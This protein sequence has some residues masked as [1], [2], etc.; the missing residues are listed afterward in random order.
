[1]NANIQH[2]AIFI[3]IGLLFSVTGIGQ[4]A[5]SFNQLLDSIADMTP[6]EKNKTITNY[7]MEKGRL[8][9]I[10]GDTVVFLSRGLGDKAPRI[11]SGFTGFLNPRY[12]KDPE[13]GTMTNIED[14]HWFFLEKTLNP[15]A[16]IYYQIHFGD[17]RNNDPLNPNLGFRFTLINSMVQMPDFSID[18]ELV[19]D[20]FA[21]KG[22][23]K[24]I[25]I[26]SK[27]L[28][29]IRTPKVYLPAGYQDS[30]NQYPTLYFHDGTAYV[31]MGKVPQILDYLIAHQKIQPVIAVF[32]DPK[33]RGKEYRGGEGYINYIDTELVP[34]IDRQ[35]RTIPERE[36]R[37]VIG[38]SRG[39]LS[40]L[41]LSHSTK[42][43]SKCGT[44]SPA[45]IPREMVDFTS[46]LK[47]KDYQP[48]QAYVLGA[49]YDGIWYPDA[50]GLK[51]H[52]E[53]ENTQL[54]YS[55]ISQGHF[56]QGWISR[57]DE[58]LEYFFPYGE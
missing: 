18:P 39:G 21:Q 3:I 52:F 32:D 55:E 25:V 16:R 1:M 31:E 45:I 19:F 58:M 42:H 37:A 20:D 50:L 30:K 54:L 29:H 47:R 44:F 57:L 11:A 17:E 8:P 28:D 7:I 27:N 35:F 14:T 4:D 38:G 53:N 24:E 56:I 48:D 41:I 2:L 5:G 6:E 23:V 22:E 15:D 26:H 12:I 9:I 13:V 33:E 51:A 36:Q 49:I 43:F 34:E 46:F 10:E 40:S